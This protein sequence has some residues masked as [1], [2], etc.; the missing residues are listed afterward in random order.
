ML[1]KYEVL[2]NSRFNCLMSIHDFCLPVWP[3]K[4]HYVVLVNS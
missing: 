1:A 4:A 2:V 3:I